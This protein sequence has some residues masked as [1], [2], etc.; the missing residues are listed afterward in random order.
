V[1]QF[2]RA[3]SPAESFAIDILYQ[4]GKVGPYGFLKDGDDLKLLQVLMNWYENQHKPL[5]VH[6]INCSCKKETE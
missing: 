6:W 1:S 3:V 2:Q 4:V 5:L